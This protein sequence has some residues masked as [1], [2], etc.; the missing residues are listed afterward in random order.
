MRLKINNSFEVVGTVSIV[1]TLKSN[2]GDCTPEGLY[3]CHDNTLNQILVFD[4]VNEFKLLDR[5][6]LYWDPSSSN[7]GD[8]ES[9][10][11]NMILLTIFQNCE[12]I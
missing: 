9:Y 1:D 11:K 5:V 8:L 2:A 3:L 7:S 4:V 6:D 10:Q 12:F